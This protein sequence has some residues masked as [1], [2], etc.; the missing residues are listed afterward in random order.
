[1]GEIR[2]KLLQFLQDS[3][4]YSPQKVLSQLDDHLIEEKA[5]VF[6]RLKRHEEALA[7]YTNLFRDFEAAEK[8]C[9]RYYSTIDPVNSTVFFMLFK[10]Y[11]KPSEVDLTNLND[12]WAK[13]LKPNVNEALKLLRNHAD[14]MDT[15]KI[16]KLIK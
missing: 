1:M 12:K 13:N 11:T 8:H 4:G 10:L 6:G 14:K 9:L 7:I 3:T 16:L 2:R 5:I 15:G